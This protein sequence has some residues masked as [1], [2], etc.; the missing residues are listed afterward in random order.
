MSRSP[1]GF[2]HLT[3]STKASDFPKRNT[4]SHHLDIN[5]KVDLYCILF[6]TNTISS[7]R[8]GFKTTIF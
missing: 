3:L 2:M 7:A 6:Y 5:M 8:Y 1:M 4:Y